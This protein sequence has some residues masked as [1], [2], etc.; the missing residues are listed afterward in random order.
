MNNK[1]RFN[2][3]MNFKPVDRYLNIETG[4]WPQTANR[5]ISEGLPED[6]ILPYFRDE[7]DWDFEV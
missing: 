4:P 3:I 7:K 2:N 1:Q 6:K 5:W